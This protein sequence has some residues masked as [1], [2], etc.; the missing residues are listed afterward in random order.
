[1]RTITLPA[2]VCKSQNLK[3]AKCRKLPRCKSCSKVL[4][5]HWHT[6]LCFSCE[7]R[8]KAE[9]A[10]KADPATRRCEHCGEILLSTFADN[11]CQ[12]CA[13]THNV[14]EVCHA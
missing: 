1:M 2:K 6:G 10:A 7:Q 3:T 5:F 12:R 11:A 13:T 8:A 14:K 9:A 4:N